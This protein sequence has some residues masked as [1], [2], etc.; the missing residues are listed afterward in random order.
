M[1][2]KSGY[3]KNGWGAFKESNTS[4]FVDRCTPAGEWAVNQDYVFSV[5]SWTEA[6]RLVD[7]LA[8]SSPSDTTPL[9]DHFAGLAMQSIFAG[10]GARMV[11]DRDERYNETNWA[12]VVAANA[13]EM[14]DAMLAHRSNA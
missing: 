1:A 5:L 11:A 10:E 13:Y 3:H 12:Q 6:R 9:R 8:G 2:K 7:L 4:F 14:A